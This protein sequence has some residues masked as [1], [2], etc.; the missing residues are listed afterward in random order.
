MNTLFITATESG[1]DTVASFGSGNEAGTSLQRRAKGPAKNATAS[2]REVAALRRRI[3]ASGITGN[4]KAARARKALLQEIVDNS[5]RKG[6][7]IRRGTLAS[8]AAD[9]ADL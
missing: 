3:S 7:G 4:S 2:P 1:G 9:F 8:I 5:G 6:G